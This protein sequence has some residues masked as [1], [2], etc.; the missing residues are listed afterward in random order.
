MAAAIAAWTDG[1]SRAV[2]LGG[3]HAAGH[4]VWRTSGG[5]RVPLSDLDLYV[6]VP[7]RAVQARAQR[8]MRDHAPALDLG[9]LASGIEVAFLTP[10]DLAALPA[11]PGT[12]ELERHAVTLAGDPAWAERVPA[13]DGRAVSREERALL[14]ENRAFELLL[15]YEPL[16]AEAAGEGARLPAWHAVMKCRLE[17]A[18]ARCLDAGE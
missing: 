15:A 5:V 10:A 14:I 12:L 11:R 13:R 4:A 9:D 6:V 8:R 17:L 18:A 7:D 3:S 16:A 1:R 2:L